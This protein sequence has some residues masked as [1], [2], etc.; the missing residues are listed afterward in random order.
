MR[1]RVAAGIGAALTAAVLIGVLARY[2][3][4]QPPPPREAAPAPVPRS[5]VE[6]RLYCEF[7]NFA[8]RTPRVGFYFTAP[9]GGTDYAQI[10]Q[11]E[12]DGEQT[13][14]DPRPTWSYDR[15]GEPPTLHSPDGAIT[16]NL[17]G[18]AKNA[19][20]PASAASGGWFEAGLRSVQYLNLE[21][22][23]RRTAT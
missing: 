4:Q 22:Q 14:F 18:D 6:P 3:G 19:T 9:A 5:A 15:A 8:S 1:T 23:C 20:R 21:G 11:R 10:F 16:I 13:I 12:T 7:Y 17:Y 2:G